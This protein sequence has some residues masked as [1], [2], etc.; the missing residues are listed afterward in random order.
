MIVSDSSEQTSDT[1]ETSGGVNGEDTGLP[2]WWWIPPV[3]TLACCL[4]VLLVVLT[5][6]KRRSRPSTISSSSCQE[7]AASPSFFGDDVEMHSARADATAVEPTRTSEYASA[8][9]LVGLAPAT[10]TYVSMLPSE[11]NSVGAPSE[12]STIVYSKI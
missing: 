3:A 8:S 1:T 4:I 12:T 9:H 11:F 10:V 6:W 5:V 2:D 7:A